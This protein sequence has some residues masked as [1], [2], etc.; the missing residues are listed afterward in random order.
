[1]IKRVVLAV[2]VLLSMFGEA[3]PQK[4]RILDL[5]N[6]NA[7]SLIER[8]IQLGKFKNINPTKLP[9]KEIEVYDELKNIDIESLS[10]VEKIWYNQLANEIGFS[11]FE[12]EKEYVVEPLL[13]SG[14][15]V[16]N[17]ERKN[18]Y[19]PTSDKLFVWPYAEASL[20]V[21]Y[22]NITI[23]NNVRFDL[24]YE[25]APDGLDAT[26]RLY[27]RNENSYLSYR[28]KYLSAYLGRAENQWGKYR[29]GSSFITEN[30]VPFDQLNYTL[31]TSKVSFSSIVGV[32]DNIGSDNV[33]DG[34]T[35]GDPN[36]IRRFVAI[37]RMD[38][39]VNENLVLTF[40]EANLYSGENT[41]IEP[42]YMLPNFLFFFL[43]AAPPK[44]QV[45]NLMIGGSIWYR[46]NSFSV[47]FDMMLD[48]LITNR[49]ERGITEKNNFAIVLNTS[50]MFRRYPAQLN[51]DFELFTYQVYNTDQAE[52]RYLYLGKGIASQFNDFIFSEVSLDYFMDLKVEGLRISPYVGLLKQGE[53]VINQPFRSTYENGKEFEYVL[54]GTVEDTYRF[55]IDLQY[56]LKQNLWLKTDLGLNIVQNKA[57]VRGVNEQR[58]NG[59]IELGF[60]LS[61]ANLFE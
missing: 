36:A 39:R 22:K 10:K 44:D 7:Y 50:Y 49:V 16:N 53:Q 19:R 11:K 46:N 21:D 20:Y 55:A 13:L 45:E 24:Y 40:K 15:E 58:F 54:T 3:F 48:D 25:F 61:F 34:I 28:S 17:S 30:A 18:T 12:T 43:E 56:Y 42:K 52:G 9:Y 14:S 57:N 23:S 27:I 41:N 33:F 37:K 1:M 35:R 2:I 8:F 6:S 59:M 51:L 5:D 38:W 60:R 29:R 32:L 26:N 31:G 47:N 4:A